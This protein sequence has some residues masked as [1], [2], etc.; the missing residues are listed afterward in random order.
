MT[1]A[2]VVSLDLTVDLGGF[3]RK[4]LEG[5]LAERHAEATDAAVAYVSRVLVDFVRADAAECQALGGSLALMLDRALEQGEPERR[6]RLRAVGDSALYLAGFFSEHLTRRGGSGP[7]C[8]ELVGTRAYGVLAESLRRRAPEA[9]PFRELARKF[10]TFAAALQAV[11]ETMSLRAVHGDGAL[12]ELYD[13][14]LRTGSTRVAAAL[15]ERGVLPA[16]RT[17]GLN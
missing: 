6:H 11:A 15:A 12:V 7:G 3:F 10:E 16:I 5:A 13:R 9:A 2:A 14:W 8:A 4:E 1:P 17:A